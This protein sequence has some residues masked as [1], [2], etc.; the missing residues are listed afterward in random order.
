MTQKFWERWFIASLVLFCAL[1]LLG[2]LPGS[3][4]L[5]PDFLF[6]FIPATINLAICIIWGTKD[7]TY[8]D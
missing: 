4:E 5:F 8:E 7:S 1:F 2:T 6:V 3:I